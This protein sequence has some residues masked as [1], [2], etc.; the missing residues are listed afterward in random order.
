MAQI[1]K[2]EILTI[3]NA[4]SV[5]RIFLIPIFAWLYSIEQNYV[6]A[7]S[8]LVISGITDILDGFIARKFDLISKIGTMLDPVADKLTQAVVLFCL[9]NRF[10]FMMVPFILLIIKEI[11]TGATNL[12]IIRKTKQ[13]I[14]AD[15]HGKM[16]TILLYAMMIIHVVWYDIPAGFSN[17][18]II[19]NIAMMIISFLLYGV[20]NIKVLMNTKQ[21]DSND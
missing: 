8:V 5:F 4:L 12:L 2:N 21:D 3:P 15:W 17:F 13:V 20:H 1:Q 16:S 6:W 18:F 10:P 11:F 19:I 14:G 9:I 7:G